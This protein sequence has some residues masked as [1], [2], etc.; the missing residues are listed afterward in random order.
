VCLVF[1]ATGIKNHFLMR[2]AALRASLRRKERAFPFFT[3]HLRASVCAK[4]RLRWLDML[5][6]FLPHLSKL[7]FKTSRRKAV[8]VRLSFP[9]SI[10][11]G[12]FSP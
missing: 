11:L 6:Y 4:P 5:G 3:Q 12:G 2:S 7:G 10:S 9:K 8:K 1:G